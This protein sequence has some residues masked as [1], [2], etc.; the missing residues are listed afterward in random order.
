MDFCKQIAF[1]L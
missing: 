1:S